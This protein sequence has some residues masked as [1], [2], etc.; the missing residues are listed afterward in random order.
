MNKSRLLNKKYKRVF[1]MCGDKQSRGLGKRGTCV[2]NC[3]S[4]GYT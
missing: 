1:V 2:E 3:S 4:D